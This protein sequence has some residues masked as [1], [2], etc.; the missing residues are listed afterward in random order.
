[1]YEKT[2]WKARKGVKL[3]RFEKSEETSRSVVLE[4]SP[5]AITE[6][7]T[8]YSTANMNKMEQ[9]IYDAHEM[10]AAEERARINGDKDTLAAAKTH[11]ANAGNISAGTLAEERLPSVDIT[12]GNANGGAAQLLTGTYSIRTIFQRLIDNIARAFSDISAKASTADLTEAAARITTIEGKIPNQASSSNQLAD[13]DFV[14]SSVTAMASHQLTYNAGGDPFPAKA[15]L[16]SA[17][18]FYYKGQP[19]APTERDYCVVQADETQNGGQVRYVYDGA[20]WVFGYKINDAP[21]TNAQA[22]ALN[23]GA[24]AA[25]INDIANKADKV[26]GS[27]AGNLAAL[28]ASGNLTDSGIRAEDLAG[29]GGLNRTVGGND[30]AV[31]TVTDTGGNLSIPIPVTTV[32]PAASNAQTAAG[33]RSLRAQIKIFVD[34]IADLFA[35]KIGRTQASS[36]DLDTLRAKGF[37][38]GT[39]T[40]R[41]GGVSATYG[42]CI[43]QE[44][45]WGSATYVNQIYIPEGV[46]QSI[47]YRTT[48]SISSWGA[49]KTAAGLESPAFTGTPTA[50]EIARSLIPRITAQ[51]SGNPVSSYQDWGNQIVSMNT[52]RNA[53]IAERFPLKSY[54]TQYPVPGQASL[55]GMFPA[56]RSPA[57]LYGGTWTEC[58]TDEEVFFKAGVLAA[59]ASRG[60]KYDKA[61][62]SWVDGGTPGIQGDAIQNITGDLTVTYATVRLTRAGVS[63]KGES[64]SRD[65]NTSPSFSTNQLQGS[66]TL[67]ASREV[68]VDTDNHPKNRLVKVWERTA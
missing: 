55:A 37:Y 54:Y 42:S 5:I 59:E 14:N 8:P 39:F 67:D 20:Q 9:G 1:M 36:L 58:F 19:F 49:W 2:V 4:N 30:N 41:P 15:A 10:I 45:T 46:N 53:L 56:D 38:T 44:T 7:G 13:K 35:N 52:L 18:V 65:N 33:T 3:N 22:A 27:A 25:K 62:Q 16:T 24:T 31:G 48:N 43:V 64:A 51:T 12:V 68:P 61:T 17:A 60:K 34:N 29:L 63:L 26:Q 66:I 40:N 50:P 6:P 47:F 57:V 11:A 23:S 21:F 28:D 32:T